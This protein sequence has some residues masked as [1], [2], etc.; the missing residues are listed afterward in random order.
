MVGQRNNGTHF[1]LPWQQLIAC[2][3]D[4]H[5]SG[6]T[7]FNRYMVAQAKRYK[8]VRLIWEAVAQRGIGEREMLC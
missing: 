6:H 7:V 4:R 5:I 2:V 1:I 3:A 8:Q